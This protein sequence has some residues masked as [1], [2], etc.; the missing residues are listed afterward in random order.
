MGLFMPNVERRLRRLAREV[1][2]TRD[3]KRAAVLVQLAHEY[4]ATDEPD[5]DLVIRALGV[6]AL[7]VAYHWE[8]RSED[9]PL[10]KAINFPPG[11]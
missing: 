7:V 8:T 5:K 6:A 10:K 11:V 2:E 4:A 3:V 9:P 1:L